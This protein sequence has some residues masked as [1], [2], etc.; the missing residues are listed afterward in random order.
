[1]DNNI[2]LSASIA[3]RRIIDGDT[4]S[5]WFSTNGVPLHQGLNP[6][7]YQATPHWTEEAGKTGRPRAGDSPGQQASC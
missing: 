1:M 3:I 4:L 7:D 6:N 5:L 2:S